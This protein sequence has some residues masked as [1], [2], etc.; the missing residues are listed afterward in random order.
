M[1]QYDNAAHDFFYFSD[2][3]VFKACDHKINQIQ[4][5]KI[6]LLLI[7]ILYL[8]LNIEKNTSYSYFTCLFIFLI[9]MLLNKR[10]YLKSKF[11]NNMQMTII[12]QE[13]SLQK[14]MK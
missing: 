8:W 7:I 14:G 4:I 10:S 9:V 6:N 1:R 5:N 3:A 11:Y 12:F 13:K 2:W